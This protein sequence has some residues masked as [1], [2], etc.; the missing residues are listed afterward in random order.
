MRLMENAEIVK[1]DVFGTKA[2]IMEENE[3]GTK[4]QMQCDTPNGFMHCY[5]LF[6]GI[7]LAY[8]TFE[9]S[10]CRMRNRAM[11]NILEIAYCRAGRFECEYKHGFV[12]YLGEGDFA[13][14][15]LSPER[16]PPEFPIG[17]YDGVAFIID[18][19]ITGLIFEN[20]VEGV[21]I[22]LKELI[23]KFCVGHCCSVIKTPPNL[24]HVFQEICEA[25]DTVPMGYLRL[26]VLESLFLLSQ[27]LPQENF[28][29]AAYY[30]ANQIKKVKALK[31]ELANQLDSR[32]TLKSI[33]DRY[34]MSL[35]ALKDCFKAV[36]GK[37]IHTFQREYKMQTATKLLVTTK[38]SIAEIAGMV[39]YENPNKFSA[40]FKEIIGQS[41]SE[42]R[43]SRK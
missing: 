22:N 31:Y 36:Y 3:N 13:I 41:P 16:E 38:L 21:S 10:S 15:L 4:Y 17:Y 27:M 24:R 39:G 1:L 12:T 8:S 35:T 20:I 11:P 14:S 40:A 33:A 23:D 34:G 37:P 25:R 7:D 42:Y 26:K 9:A 32:E 30:S 43:K 6:P 19:D 5:H 28:E 18:L 2:K 29:T